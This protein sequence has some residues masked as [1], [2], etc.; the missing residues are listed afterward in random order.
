MLIL[1]LYS[2]QKVCHSHQGHSEQTRKESL[3]DTLVLVTILDN[4]LTRLLM[5]SPRCNNAMTGRRLSYLAIFYACHTHLRVYQC[6]VVYQRCTQREYSSKPLKH[7][8]VKRILVF[9]R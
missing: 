6:I 1:K 9:K 3:L 8:I 2:A 5:F 4:S 7:N